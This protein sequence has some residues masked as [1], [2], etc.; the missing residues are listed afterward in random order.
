MSTIREEEEPAEEPTVAE[1][2]RAEAKKGGVSEWERRN[3]LYHPYPP[4]KRREILPPSRDHVLKPTAVRDGSRPGPPLADL[5]VAP[6]FAPGRGGKKKEKEPEQTHAEAGSARAAALSLRPRADARPL[7][8]FKKETGAPPAL[9][10]KP[11]VAASPVV[12]YHRQD[13]RSR[14]NFTRQAAEFDEDTAGAHRNVARPKLDSVM[15]LRR[16][17]ARDK[18][19]PYPKPEGIFKGYSFPD[20]ERK[21][22]SK[23]GK[24]ALPVAEL[25]AEE[26]VEHAFVDK[27]RLH[28]RCPFCAATHCLSTGEDGRTVAYCA[29]YDYHREVTSSRQICDYNR[30]HEKSTHMILACPSLVQRCPR[31]ACRGHG[32]KDACDLSNR[33]VMEALRADYEYYADK[34]IY[35]P[36]RWEDKPLSAAWGWFPMNKT[37]ADTLDYR[38]LVSLSVGEALELVEARGALQPAGAGSQQAD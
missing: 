32:L 4:R 29:L 37:A 22:K 12:T 25:T 14:I 28:L 24:Y 17:V 30:C 21:G 11:A 10:L 34:H 19:R 5:S 9:K 27:P 38:Y 35:G 7:S 20:Q 33:A 26:L 2:F 8:T 23:K 15:D 18:N 16:R 31:C 1:K 13:V 6:P 3:V 36:R